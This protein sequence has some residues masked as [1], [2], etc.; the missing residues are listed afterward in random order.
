MY[1]YIFIF[2]IH[3]QRA[4]HVIY[5]KLPVKRSICKI[6]EKYNF[7]YRLVYKNTWKTLKANLFIEENME[8][9]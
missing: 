4:K 8:N 9:V 1:S 2:I 5:C 3:T 6:Y 7:I